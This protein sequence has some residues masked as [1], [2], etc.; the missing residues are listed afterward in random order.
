MNIKKQILR[1]EIESFFFKKT[2][3][4]EFFK[5]NLIFQTRNS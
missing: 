4:D 1:D 5:P 2:T 3:L